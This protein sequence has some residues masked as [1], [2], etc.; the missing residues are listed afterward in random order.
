MSYHILFGCKNILYLLPLAYI[1]SSPSASSRTPADV[2]CCSRYGQT[3]TCNTP[4]ETSRQTIILTATVPDDKSHML[5]KTE[6]QGPISCWASSSNHTIDILVSPLRNTLYFIHFAFHLFYN[7][8]IFSFKREKN[9]H[10]I[11]VI[12]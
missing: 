2:S 11:Y 8:I 9:C 3:L 4:T 5:V 1:M 10:F 7:G 12:F 6:P